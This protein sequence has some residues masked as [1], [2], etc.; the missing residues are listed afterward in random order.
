[1]KATR[2]RKVVAVAVAAREL[3]IA[4]GRIRAGIGDGRYPAVVCGKCT[5]VELGGLRAAIEREDERY[6]SLPEAA[7]ALGLG[8]SLLYRLVR[9]GKIGRAVIGKEKKGDVVAA[10]EWLDRELGVAGDGENLVHTR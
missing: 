5:Y 7:Q 8:Y 2:K 6:K 4:P 1:M 9:E 3:K 10:R